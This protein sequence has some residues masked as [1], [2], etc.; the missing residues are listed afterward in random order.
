MRHMNQL[1]VHLR[2]SEDLGVPFY[3]G[4]V[5]LLRYV[6]K[7]P[8]LSS[9]ARQTTCDA[10]KQ[11]AARP[12]S[13]EQARPFSNSPAGDV[14]PGRNL[15]SGTVP[16]PVAAHLAQ[17]VDPTGG[18]APPLQSPKSRRARVSAG[19]HLRHGAGCGG[20]LAA[21]SHTMAKHSQASVW[22][23][24]SKYSFQNLYVHCN[25][26]EPVYVGSQ[27]AKVILTHG[28]NMDKQTVEDVFIPHLMFYRLSQYQFRDI[29]ID[30]RDNLGRPIPFQGGVVTATLY[31]CQRPIP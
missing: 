26:S 3:T 1:R 27:M 13:Q 15:G 11:R 30:I 4:L 5:G 21:G 24:I 25:I 16:A 22:R 2:N 8:A 12:V 29:E 31:F 10:G 7:G 23:T 14:V 6:H 17:C 19:G 28:F 20:R 9:I 18:F